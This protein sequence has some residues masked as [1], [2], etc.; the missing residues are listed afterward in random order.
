[1][2]VA[3]VSMLLLGGG[4]VLLAAALI[5]G[6]RRIQARKIT[7]IVNQGNAKG[8]IVQTYHPAAQ[9]AASAPPVPVWERILGVLGGIASIVGLVLTFL[10]KE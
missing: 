5:G 8:D 7:G 1:M 4:L 10:P 6:G 3:D 2:A 9:P